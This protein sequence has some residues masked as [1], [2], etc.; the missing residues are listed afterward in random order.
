VIETIWILETPG[1]QEEDASER[2]EFNLSMLEGKLLL[3]Y[4]SA[5]ECLFYL[6]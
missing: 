2:R 3:E 4:W 6:S 5:M 1:V